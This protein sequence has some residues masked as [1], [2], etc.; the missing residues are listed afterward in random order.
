RWAVQALE[1]AREPQPGP[2]AGDALAVLVSARAER[3]TFSEAREL[4]RASRAP[5]STRRRHALARLLLAEGR[6]EDAYAEASEV[7]A[8]RERQGRPNPTWDGW[9][10]TAALALAHLG[11]RAEATK[12]AETE[13]AR[14]RS[15]GAPVPI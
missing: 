15:F 11:R 13:L 10:S 4:L 7:G 2:F 5:H 3:G 6:F 8:R 1:L 14:A 12:L 9:R